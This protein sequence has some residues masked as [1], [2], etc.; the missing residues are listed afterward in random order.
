MEACCTLVFELFSFDCDIQ[1]MRE[2]HVRDGAA[3]T[4]F[5]SW[6]D[7][8]MAKGEAGG[9]DGMGWPLTEYSVAEKL[10]CFR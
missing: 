3:A 10:N 8:T 4:S 1:G 6:L 9:G 5:L 2:A 7:R